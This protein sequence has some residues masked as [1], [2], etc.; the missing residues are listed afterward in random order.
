MLLCV[1]DPRV[2]HDIVAWRRACLDEL[3]RRDPDGVRRWIATGARAGSDP[4]RFLTAAT[5]PRRADQL[6]GRQP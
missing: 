6:D 1:T 5:T 2:A 3:C 4:T